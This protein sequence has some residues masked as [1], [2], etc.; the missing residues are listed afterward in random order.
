MALAPP[1]EWPS[2][3]IGRRVQII[4]IDPWDFVTEN[5]SHR[6]GVIEAGAGMRLT[7]LLDTPV[8]D[9][10]RAVTAVVA[11]LRHGGTTIAGL[12]SG[13]SLSFNFLLEEGVAPHATWRFR[14]I[15]ELRLQA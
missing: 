2:E 14:F 1:D 5:G 13:L 7:I 9:Q 8:V 12:L 3:I 15:G 10:S 11:S 6:T 4:I